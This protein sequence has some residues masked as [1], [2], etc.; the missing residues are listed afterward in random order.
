[1][2]LY[3]YNDRQSGWGEQIATAALERGHAAKLIDLQTYVWE[4]AEGYFFARVEQFEPLHAVSKRWALDVASREGIKSVIQARDLAH[5]ERKDLQALDFA[6]YMP[7]TSLCRRVS[8]AERAL[9]VLGLPLVSKAA[10]GSSSSDVRLLTTRDEALSEA[11][12]ALTTGLQRTKRGQ[13]KGYVLWQ[14]Y[15]PDNHYVYRVAAIGRYRW[16]LQVF[17]R[18]DAPFASGSGKYKPVTAFDSHALNAL[19]FADKFFTDT[20]MRWGA[21]DLA[22]DTLLG[23][24]RVLE[25]TLAWNMRAPTANAA[26]PVVEGRYGEPH[27]KG[28]FGRDMW[29]LLLDEIEEGV[30]G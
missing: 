28:Y 23:E 8:C 22:Y 13:Q 4:D 14:R 25:T 9:G 24:W 12:L 30:F 21:V 10:Y 19:R 11:V 5:Y 2:M 7:Q 26:C 17:N 6:A 18:E 29:Q 3:A 15:L 20:G 1:M 16:M 27:A